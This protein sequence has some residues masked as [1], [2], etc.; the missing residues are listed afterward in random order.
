MVFNLKN[1]IQR[2]VLGPGLGYKTGFKID[3]SFLANRSRQAH[4]FQGKVARLAVKNHQRE[5]AT[6]K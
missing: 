3:E 6:L 2:R 4:F 1:L 5:I